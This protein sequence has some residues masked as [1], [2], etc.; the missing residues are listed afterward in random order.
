[1]PQQ[2]MPLDAGSM[3][4]A[5]FQRLSGT[6]MMQNPNDIIPAGYDL[7]NDFRR[8]SLSIAP[9][10]V[11]LQKHVPKLVGG[12]LD[13]KSSGRNSLLISNEMQSL[14]APDR[15]V[16]EDLQEYYRRC[17]PEGNVRNYYAL[18]RLSPAER[19]E[20]QVNLLG[21]CPTPVNLRYPIYHLRDEVAAA[22]D[23]TSDYAGL[24]QIMY[25]M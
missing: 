4:I 19:V 10:L 13:F 25:A 11:S 15:Q 20:G 5:L 12:T 24:C 1:M 7:Y 17:V 21:E 16:G 6:M 8:E 22:Y 2:I 3:R 18:A 9:Y 14:K 23:I